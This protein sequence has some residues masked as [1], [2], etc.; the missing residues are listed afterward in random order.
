MLVAGWFSL[1]TM[2][3]APTAC[4]CDDAAQTTIR[5]Q[6]FDRDPGWEGHNNRVVA[7][8]YPTVTQDFGY[9]PTSFAASEAGEVGGRVTRT[10]KPAYYGEKIR[11]K[12]LDDKLSAS[13]T[14]ALMECAASGGVFFGWFGAEQPGGGGRPLNS[15]GLEFAGEQPGARLAVTLVTR[16]NQVCRK[17]VTPVVPGVPARFRPAP[18]KK[19]GTHY[20]WTLRYDPQANDGNGRF[21][22]TITSDSA[23]PAEFEGQHVSVDVPEE[24]RKDGATFDHFGLMNLMK[25]GGPMSIYFG[26]LRDDGQPLNLVQD[27]RWDEAG[28]REVYRDQDQAGAHDFGFSPTNFAGG[29]PGEL[30]GKFWRTPETYGYVSDRIGPLSLDNRLE[31]S[32]KVVLQVG[33]PDSGMYLGWF[34]SLDKKI[35]PADSGHFLGVHVGGPTRVGHRFEPCCASAKGNRAQAQAGPVLVPGKTYDWS[36]VYDPTA[37]DGR[38]SIQLTLGRESLSFALKP[39]I[40]SEG[41]SFDRFGLFTSTVGGALVRIYFDDLKYTASRRNR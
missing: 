35:S 22:C 17:F 33:A 37:A 10:N 9:S 24:I 41:A 31:A 8:V 7:K 11:N 20:H 40:R 4:R 38:G 25:A 32:G 14:F 26:D 16:T 15:L 19:D 3:L 1:P 28:N 30:G 27:P 39:G 5:A 18:L 6:S 34:N 13:G 2:M 12:T 21:E 29:S 23:H 36:L